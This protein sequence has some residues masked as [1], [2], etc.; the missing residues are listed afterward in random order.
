MK[1]VCYIMKMLTP[2][3]DDDDSALL[4]A[5]ITLRGSQGH[6]HNGKDYD[7]QSKVLAHN[8]SGPDIV[9]VIKI[10]LRF[11]ELIMMVAYPKVEL[12]KP[13]QQLFS[14]RNKF[15]KPTRHLQ[16]ASDKT[17]HIDVFPQQNV[18][19]CLKKMNGRRFHVVIVGINK[20]DDPRTPALQGC[21]N[22]A[23]LFR[24]YVIHD[25]SVP[26]NQITL[27]LSPAGNEILPPTLQ[28]IPL[29]HNTPSP[30]RENILNALYHLHDSPNIKPDDSIIIFYAGH[31][32]TYYA[33]DG[34]TPRN[35]G[36]IEAISPVDRNTWKP[37]T[38]GTAEIV[39]DISDREIN[40]I[41]GE[42]AKKKCNN[43]TLILDCC[44]SGSGVRG[45]SN[46]FNSLQLGDKEFLTSRYCP[47]I[48]SAVP[49]MFKAADEAGRLSPDRPRT[50]DLNFR[51]NMKSHV[52]IAAAKEYQ[53][54][55][56]YKDRITGVSQGY[57]TSR[58]LTALRS[59]LGCNPTTTY[60]ELIGSPD[61]VMPFQTA[62]VAGRKMARLWFACEHSTQ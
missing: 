25:L 13:F 28:A 20:Y 14:T 58:F 2:Q 41:F 29:P 17:H 54:A 62:F 39:V 12:L 19:S 32:Q 60:R 36:S 57:F 26:A 5:S 50:A 21:V 33:T 34:F 9:A 22:D 30:T 53:E 24:H 45:C 52:L 31:G 18:S 37:N 8:R 59:P 35:T 40:V 46:A 47:S 48:P 23:L 1:A 43:I 38:N 6:P 15:V 55:L 16:Q 42:I 44:H 10:E 11:K 49:L 7:C 61:L 51:A 3:I 56:E 4:H 27:L